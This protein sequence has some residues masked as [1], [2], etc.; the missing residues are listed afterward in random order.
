M[1]TISIS[2]NRARLPRTIA[3]ISA[4]AAGVILSATMV[5]GCA[6]DPQ[7]NALVQREQEAHALYTATTRAVDDLKTQVLTLPDDSPVKSAIQKRL[8][9]LQDL[10]S[11][12]DRYI[13]V[14]D[15]A[16]AA[17]RAKGTFDPTD[18]AWAP[19]AQAIPYGST[20]LAI[21]GLVW[22]VIG[23]SRSARNGAALATVVRSVEAALP[24]KSDAVKTALAAVQGP[25]VWALVDEIKKRATE[26]RGPVEKRDVAAK[27]A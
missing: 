1:R 10:E 3:L 6:A 8:S 18:P 16:I 23:Q 22:G 24:Q 7:L 11:K 20:A 2:R 19:I 14:A 15:Q 27:P 13:Q 21:A 4:S 26:P 12:T 9:Q 25:Q 5:G 17:L